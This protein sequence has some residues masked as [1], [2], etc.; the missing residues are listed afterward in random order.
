MSWWRRMVKR[1]EMERQLTDE[2]QF[3]IESAVADN[4]H[5]GMSEPEARRQARLQFGGVEQVKEECRDARG[6]RWLETTLQDTR[7]ALRWLRKSPGFALAVIAT[8]A[9]GIGANT[10]MFSV[11]NG[12]LLSPLP[13][14]QPDR[15][16]LIHETAPEV[17]LLSVP[18]PD[19][20]DWQEQNHTLTEIAAFRGAGFSLTGSGEAEQLRGRMV[21]ASLFSILHVKP[22]LGRTFLPDEDRP[23][24]R[25]VVL[26][27][28]GIWRRRFGADPGILIRTLTL[29]GTT[30]TVIGVLP[31]NFRFP[32]GPPSGASDEVFVPLGEWNSPILLDRKFHPGI[33]VVGRIKAGESLASANA[34]LTRIGGIL[35]RE[36]PATNTGHGISV[37]SLKDMI[38]GDVRPLLYVLLGAVGF[39][40]LIACANVANL[41][42]AR[43]TAR[44]HEMAI[45]TA[46]GASRLRL[47]RQ[48]LTESTLLALAG[49]AAGLAL[50]PLATM[51]L[52][53]VAPP[54]LARMDEIA[55]DGRVLAFALVASLF[56]GLVFGLAPALQSSRIGVGLQLGGRTVLSGRHWLRDGLV[57]CEIALAL[58]L[59]AG[60]GLMIRTIWNL[61]GVNP[62]FDPH[63]VLRFRIGLSPAESSHVGAI[64]LAYTKLLDRI[65]RVPGVDF[66]AV[67]EAVPMDGNDETMPVWIE[68]RPRPQSMGDMPWV[69]FHLTSSD[70]RRVLNIPLIRGRFFSEHDNEKSGTVAVIDETAARTLFPAEDPIGKR[71]MIG[72]PDLG[73]QAQIVG[74][75]GHVLRSG[76]DDDATTKFRAQLYIPFAQLPD[77]YL[78]ALASGA[79]IIVRTKTNPLALPGTDHQGIWADPNQTV[80]DIRSMDQIIAATLTRR[81]FT[82]LLLGVFAVLAVV[83]AAIGIYG[84]M[85]YS[86]QQRTQ[87]IGIRLALGAQPGTVRNM[88]I[89][90]GMRLVLIGVAIGIA[91]AFGLTRLLASF[92]FGVQPRDPLVFIAVPLLLAAVALFAC[93]LPARRATRINPMEALRW[94]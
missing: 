85:T 20:L 78:K 4:I 8:L 77:F 79:T 53:R 65:R 93:Y 9:L 69:Q 86:I 35:A 54:G 7:F 19:F 90:H 60:G 82:M 59:L 41:L 16:V 10:A 29:N 2:L 49:G 34:D 48:L 68:G 63:H 70:Y 74:I 1:A 25:S 23:G 43:A 18:Y 92:L 11:V 80:F 6:T 12:V 81:R 38:V 15:L 42:L 17:N 88:I 55:I 58:V 44:Q 36:Y 52:L 62:G 28:E 83:L 56:T 66:A 24:G 72:G 31:S 22:I 94:E 67:T 3:H 64:R 75:V 91:A 84:L 40:L 50:A 73:W 47:V 57:A 89:L 37:I 51:L 39:L 45:R 61:G 14:P 46:I 13:Y 5:A 30:Y 21:S 32:F 87:E 33:L 76:L 27:S 71:V 26:I